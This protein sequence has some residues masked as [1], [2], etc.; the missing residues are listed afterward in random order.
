MSAK[1]SAFIALILLVSINAF[2]FEYKNED[3]PADVL[4]W[5]S[6]GMYTEDESPA[7]G[8]PSNG[9]SYVSF[10]VKF[11][12][13]NYVNAE[14]PVNEVEVAI[15]ETNSFDKLGYTP[16]GEKYKQY[17]CNEVA[18]QEGVCEV[19]NTIIV[20][21]D[22]RDEVKLWKVQ[23][24]N[25][26]EAEL[27]DTYNVIRSGLHFILFSRCD[28]GEGDV[29]LEGSTEWMNPYGYLDG[30]LFGSLGFT[31][32]VSMAYLI[33]SSIW[34]VMCLC[35]WKE[36]QGVQNW[37]CVVLSTC[38]IE[39]AAKYFELCDWNIT[40]RRSTVYISTVIFFGTFK[41]SLARF[42]LLIV[43]LGY[44]IVKPSLGSTIYKAMFLSLLYFI[45]CFIQRIV[46]ETSHGAPNGVLMY[47]LLLP[48]S[49]LNFIFFGW[50]FVALTTTITQLKER[51]QSAKLW[52]FT[53]FRKLL[54]FVLFIAV[55]WYMFYFFQAMTHHF[56]PSYS[57]DWQ[58]RWIYGYFFEI[59]FLGLFSMISFLW[60]PSKNARA[61]AYMEQLPTED[62][63]EGDMGSRAQDAEEYLD[64]LEDSPRARPHK[65]AGASVELVAM[66]T[67]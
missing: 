15:F 63:E 12:R 61:Y 48:V 13:S 22:A 23:F 18:K 9:K 45:A 38:M 56:D 10:D 20:P 41:D 5:G 34:F 4:L 54:A 55:G 52:L 65:S 43:S 67:V 19:L 32:W 7:I 66:K 6:Q 39:A 36:L 21:E 29:E 35:S 64:G 26:D 30:T 60:R 31:A 14:E 50:I 24:G 62:V 16:S 25:Q 47:F 2:I 27:V 57:G 17:C 33:L 40:G 53:T 1:Y 8:Y 44:G 28:W 11:K 42:L 51:N 49:F 37:I 3:L 58:H 46:E 59:C